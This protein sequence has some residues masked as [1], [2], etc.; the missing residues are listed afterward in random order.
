VSP[1]IVFSFEAQEDLY[2]LQQYIA[3]RSGL[4]RSELIVDRILKTVERIAYRPG[5]G[6][7]RS[8]ANLSEGC[9]VF[10]EPPWLI[11]YIPLPDLNGIEIV[12]IVDSRRDL[13]R[14]L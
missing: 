4:L 14:T 12:R 6:S 8:L 13:D 11:I 3:E 5:I 10:V 9:R 2:Q 7:R 1:D